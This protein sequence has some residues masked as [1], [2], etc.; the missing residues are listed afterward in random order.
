MAS[1]AR[2]NIVVWHRWFGVFAALWLALMGITGSVIVLYDEL[3]IWLNPDLRLTQSTGSHVSKDLW[4]KAAENYK[5]GGQAYFIDVPNKSDTTARVFLSFPGTD[6]NR[7]DVFVDP[8]TATVQGERTIGV[9]KLN[10]QHIMDVMYGLHMDL[11]LG[12]WMLWFLGLVSVLWLIDHFLVL[13]ISFP[14]AK[15]WTKSFLIRRGTKGYKFH[16]DMHRSFGLWF[17][18]VTLVLAMSGIYF[19]WDEEAVHT[20]ELFSDVTPRHVWIMD[21][22]DTP[23]YSPAITFHKAIDV[24]QE[25]AGREVDIINFY[26]YLNAYM[27][28]AF[29]E[30]DMDP[31]GRRLITIDGQT[32]S[33]LA[34]Q[35]AASGTAGDVFLVW[36]YPLHSGKAFGWTGRI[37]I[38]LSGILLSIVCITGL[39]IWWRKLKARRRT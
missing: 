29:D 39:L 2:S 37:V 5:P 3:D 8:Y 25:R 23:E 31:H 9:L 33:I 28:R 14:S 13:F 34:D 1:K 11:L 12:D 17:F 18:P 16:Y 32:G 6:K 7:V 36:Q 15:N 4:I 27:A 20:V 19:N 30:R 22:L 21:E 24:A 35:H 38:F 10:R 26:P